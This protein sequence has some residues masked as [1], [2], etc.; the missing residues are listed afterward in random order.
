MRV[1]FQYPLVHLDSPGIVRGSLPTEYQGYYVSTRIAARVDCVPGERVVS[2][3]LPMEG[4]VEV[5]QSWEPQGSGLIY[6]FIIFAIKD[7]VVVL[8]RQP[9][10]KVPHIL[11]LLNNG[12]VTRPLVRY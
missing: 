8:S 6:S 7:G 12:P 2:A 9:L 5:P 4:S 11:K 1:S 10:L 3:C